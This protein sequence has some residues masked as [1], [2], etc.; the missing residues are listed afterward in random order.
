LQVKIFKSSLG[1]SISLPQNET[2][3]QDKTATLVLAAGKVSG[4]RRESRTGAKPIKH[5]IKDVLPFQA[6]YQSRRR[7]ASRI[8]RARHRA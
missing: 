5:Y 4:K 2:R 1:G 3:K 8:D 7:A 6:Q